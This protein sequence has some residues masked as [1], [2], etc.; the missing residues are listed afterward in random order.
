MNDKRFEAWWASNPARVALNP[1]AKEVARGIW[2]AAQQDLATELLEINPAPAGA[3][4]DGS[5]TTAAPASLN[6]R[7]IS[8][9]PPR[10][11]CPLASSGPTSL[12]PRAASPPACQIHETRTI[13]LSASSLRSESPISP[14]FQAAPCA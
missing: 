5:E 7:S 4:F 2:R 6:I 10:T 11:F 9:E 12:R 3:S 1:A 8:R 14:V 13:P